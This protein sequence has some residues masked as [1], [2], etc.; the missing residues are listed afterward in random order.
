MSKIENIIFATVLHLMAVV[1]GLITFLFGIGISTGICKILA[2][3]GLAMFV[4][5]IG[6]SFYDNVKTILKY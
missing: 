5:G 3:F 2:I 4:F 1:I 6:F